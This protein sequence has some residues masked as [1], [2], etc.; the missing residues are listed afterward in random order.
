MFMA[1]ISRRRVLVLSAL[2]TAFI[3]AVALGP[4]IAPHFV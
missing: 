4:V 2:K 3:T 1:P